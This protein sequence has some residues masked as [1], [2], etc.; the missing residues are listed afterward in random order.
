MNEEIFNIIGK[1]YVDFYQ[2]KSYIEDLQNQIKQ[3]DQE[4]ISLKN[5][6]NKE[7]E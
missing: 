3:K 2:M 6:I 5:S 7:N 1:M 4:I